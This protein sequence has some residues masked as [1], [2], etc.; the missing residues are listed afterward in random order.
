MK[1]T[2][3][4]I[5]G[6]SLKMDALF[7]RNLT[8]IIATIFIWRGVWNLSDHFFFPHNFLT[9]NIT[10]I[11]MGLILLF[12]FDSEIEEI[13]EEII[14]TEKF[15]SDEKKHKHKHLLNDLI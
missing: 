13:E 9:S 15:E 3:K 2:R 12:I 4:I 7:F 6:L 5:K 11:I 14:E 1:K 8:L 10:M